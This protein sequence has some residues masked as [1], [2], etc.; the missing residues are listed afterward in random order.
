M[1]KEYSKEDLWKIYDK[2][3]DELKETVFSGRTAEKISDTCERNGI[4][5]GEKISEVA[6][7]VGRVLMGLL[8]PSEFQETLEKE[9]TLKKEVAKSIAEDIERYVFH[10]VKAELEALYGIEVSPPARP[11]E[12][13]PPSQEKTIPPKKD[14]Y[15]EPLE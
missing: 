2:L 14:I 15:R 1:E 4:E 11:T 3:P 12:I 5:E 8:P 10:P 7:Y 9:L 6:K 13:I